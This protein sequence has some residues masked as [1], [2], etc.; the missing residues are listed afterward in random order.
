MLFS[1]I[2]SAKVASN[3]KQNYCN[4]ANI[5][6][7]TGVVELK[8]DPQIRKMAR[9]LTSLL[10]VV[11]PLEEQAEAICKDISILLNSA[12]ES[13]NKLSLVTS[14]IQKTYEKYSSNF[15]FD[16]FSKVSELYKELNSTFIDWGR[17]QKSS[18][19][20]WFKNIRMIFAFSSQEI[21]GM[22]NVSLQSLTPA[23]QNQEQLLRGVQG[24]EN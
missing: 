19:D 7:T 17:V 1:S 8:M 24:E 11:K 22:E 5:H 10:K 21:Q 2:P 18:T 3:H 23:R 6:T 13:F 20:N 14:Q 12:N 15:D 9:E 4:L 16:H